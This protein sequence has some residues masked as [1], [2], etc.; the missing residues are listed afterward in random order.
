VTPE[1]LEFA[2][3]IVDGLDDEND[4]TS[5]VI[6]RYW[7]SRHFVVQPHGTLMIRLQTPFEAP[8]TYGRDL[9]AA[10]HR[11]YQLVARRG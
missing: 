3:N 6:E 4:S 10:L 1:A 7:A 5:A 9:V 11:A 8:T 2:M